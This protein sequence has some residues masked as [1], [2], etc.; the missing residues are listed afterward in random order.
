MSLAQTI[1]DHPFLPHDA[2]AK[3]RAALDYVLDHLRPPQ[4]PRSAISYQRVAERFSFSEDPGEVAK[5]LRAQGQVSADVMRRT[6]RMPAPTVWMEWPIEMT[7]GGP[8]RMGALLDQLP[9][10]GI[11]V[12]GVLLIWDNRA[13]A[14]YFAMRICDLPKK[15]PGEELEAWISWM[16]GHDSKSDD[17]KTEATQL[18]WDVVGALFLLTT[19]RVCEIR[20]QPKSHRLQKARERRGRPPLVEVKQVTLNVGIG[21]PRYERGDC[22][23]SARHEA[24]ARHRRLHPVLGHMRTYEKGRETPHVTWVPHHWRG[25]PELGI[26]IHDHIVKEKQ[27]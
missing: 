27:V 24:D 21:R 12:M 5:R 14:P 26:V 11:A 1:I 4:D 19:P 13:A 2:D 9:S 6:A 8:G 23:P 16:M 20:P 10:G 7:E 17:A 18:G 25:D 15:N 22:A 3:A